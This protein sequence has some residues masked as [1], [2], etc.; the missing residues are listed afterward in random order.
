MHILTESQ[1]KSYISSFSNDALAHAT[2]HMPAMYTTA[3]MPP[4]REVVI[5]YLI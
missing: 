5:V 4:S 3:P 2:S 1:V